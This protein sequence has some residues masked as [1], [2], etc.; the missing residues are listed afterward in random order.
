MTTWP[1]RKRQSIYKGIK[2]AILR[3]QGRQTTHRRH[4][5]S[6]LPVT[7]AAD[8]SDGRRLGSASSSN[9]SRVHNMEGNLCPGPR[10]QDV[11]VP[12][13]LFNVCTRR[14]RVL[15]AGSQT[16]SRPTQMAQALIQKFNVRHRPYCGTRERHRLAY[17]GGQSSR[18]PETQVLFRHR[19]PM[20]C[21]AESG[22]GE[23]VASIW[24]RVVY[25]TR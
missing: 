16:M 10:L 25:M 1:H 2:E 11:T 18:Y 15:L 8:R 4:H 24:R 5:G 9:R 6:P 14:S 17:P 19:Q 7:R 12:A 21:R 20:Y 22:E 23:K 13:Q 3:A